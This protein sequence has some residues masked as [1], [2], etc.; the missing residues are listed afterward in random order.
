[1]GVERGG[2]EGFHSR[3]NGEKQFMITAAKTRRV[4]R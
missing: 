1:M 3:G 2:E 4:N